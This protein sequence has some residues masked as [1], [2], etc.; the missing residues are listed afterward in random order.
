MSIGSTIDGSLARSPVVKVVWKEGL[1]ASSKQAL[2]PKPVE[3]PY[4]CPLALSWL[5]AAITSFGV[6]PKLSSCKL[7]GYRASWALWSFWG[8][9]EQL[10]DRCYTGTP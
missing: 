9:S 1:R 3:H 7:G 6:Y 4:S 2:G 8:P 5:E 10:L